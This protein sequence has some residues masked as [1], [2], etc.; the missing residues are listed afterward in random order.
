MKKKP[1]KIGWEI[2][3]IENWIFPNFAPPPIYLE[4]GRSL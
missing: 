2:K 1:I 3:K 4:N